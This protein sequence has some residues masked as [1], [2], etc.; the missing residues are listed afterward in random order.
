MISPIRINSGTGSKVKLATE[1]HR[2]KISCFK[3]IVP[4]QRR[5]AN[6]TFTVKKE[7]DTGIPKNNRIKKLPKISAK[8]SH[9]SNYAYLSGQISVL[10]NPL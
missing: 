9:H 2:L 5:K 7:K 1:D 4:P 3:P 6:T 8:A 10:S